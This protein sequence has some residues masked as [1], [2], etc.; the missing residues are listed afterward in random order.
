MRRKK[1]KMRKKED[2]KGQKKVKSEINEVEI[3]GK[4]GEKGRK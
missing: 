4:R 2:R 1:K 3:N